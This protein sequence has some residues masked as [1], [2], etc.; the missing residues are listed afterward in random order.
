MQSYADAQLKEYKEKVIAEFDN[1]IE[2]YR[3]AMEGGSEAGFDKA[4]YALGV[5]RNL[6][7]KLI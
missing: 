4:N 3:A 5:V 7:I 2:F 1:D 6:K